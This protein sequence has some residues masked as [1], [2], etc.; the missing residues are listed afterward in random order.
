MRAIP[1]LG[2]PTAWSTMTSITIPAL[3]TAAVPID[4]SSAVKTIVAWAA[5]SSGIPSAWAMKT[6]ATAM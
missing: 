6:A 1:A 3:G 5:K 4:A 2:T